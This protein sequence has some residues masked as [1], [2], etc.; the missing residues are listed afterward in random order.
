MGYNCGYS[1]Q[2][3]PNHNRN[4][5]NKGLGFVP[6]K[7]YKNEK[8]YKSK[9]VFVSGKTSEVEKEQTFRKQT[10]QEFLAKKQ[11]EL[12]KNVVQKKIETRTCYQCKTAGHIA[13]N[14]PKAFRPKQDVS[15]KFKEKMVEKTELTT[16][17]FTGFENSTFE[18]GE[19]SKNV[20]RKEN[21]KNQKWVVKGSGKGSHYESVSTKTEEPQVVKK[22]EKSVPILN[23][24]IF[25]QLSAE[26]FKKKIRKV[27]ISNQFFPKKKELDVE[28]AF[29]PVAKN[30]FGKM[31]T[32]KA[33][34]VKEFYQAKR[35]NVTPK[36]NEKITPKAGQAWVDI[37]SKE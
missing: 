28:K 22:V 12:K 30:I 14:Y 26:I 34:G 11:E 36:E 1:F 35:K 33:K 15:G 5:K 31:I 25:P 18:I 17:K 21:V 27:E 6:P 32:G 8:V 7:N 37:F 23:E 13:R 20:K 19:C 9:Y 2:K 4:F 16:R 10:N 29:N 24:K 3:K